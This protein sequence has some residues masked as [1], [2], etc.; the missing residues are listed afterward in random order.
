[1]HF[2]I[3][4]TRSPAINYVTEDGFDKLLVFLPPPVQEIYIGAYTITGFKID[5]IINILMIKLKTEKA[6]M[7]LLVF[8]FRTI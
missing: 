6:I 4:K 5:F 7:N 2:V 1:M 3:D 8:E